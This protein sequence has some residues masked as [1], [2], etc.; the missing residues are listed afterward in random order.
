MSTISFAAR[1]R[2]VSLAA[3][4]SLAALTGVASWVPMSS[5]WA[6]P[7]ERAVEPAEKPAA[8]RGE[9]TASGFVLDL[10]PTEPGFVFAAFGGKRLE[11]AAPAQ[12]SGGTA[13]QL[14]A[15][16]EAK[17]AEA[18]E[19]E[20]DGVEAAL[21]WLEDGH[22][23]ERV[24]DGWNG[25]LPTL[26]GFPSGSGQAFGV[27]WNKT[28]IGVRYPDDDTHNRFDLH[29][30]AA[31]SL[32]GYYLGLFQA[33]LARIGGTPISASGHIGYQ[34]N[35]NES[36]YGFGQGS[37]L[38][39]RISFAQSVGALGGVVWWRSPSWLYLGGAIGFRDTDIG[40]G[41]DDFPPPPDFDPTTVPGFVERVDYLNYDAFVRIDW[42]N[43]GNPYRGGLYA[44]RWTDW[45]D[46]D[47]GVFSFRELDI[48]V[49][50]YFPFLMNERVI[51]LRARTVITDTTGDQQVPF[52][53]M[54]TLGGTRDLRGY[55][56]ARFRDRNMILLNA[57]YRTEVWLAM[58]LALF[59]DAGKVVADRTDIDFD[60]LATNYG[61][62]LRVKTEQ[63]TFL[64]ADFAFGGEGFHTA[65][66]FDNIFDTTPVFSRLLQTVR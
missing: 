58:D 38:S 39:D 46:R 21:A 7:L 29:G 31:V 57:E 28:G 35:A 5:A 56:Y 47:A 17:R 53:L 63:S 62:G 59:F 37:R 36:F 2:C 32:R 64:R 33:G 60:G 61:L 11:T 30:A 6:R 1:G 43:E 48:E 50:Q 40:E 13:A 27:T 14:R 22:W 24:R 54:P 3:A 19:P 42:R 52:Y 16:R 8:S 10:P 9:G 23:L 55:N 45:N 51:A 41:S 34:F 26:G 66:T 25:F 44:V 65:I 49:Q 15:R 12:Q 20:Q 4:V 18:P